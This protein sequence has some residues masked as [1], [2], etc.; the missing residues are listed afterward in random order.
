MLNNEGGKKY[1][2]ALKFKWQANLIPVYGFKSSFVE[3]LWEYVRV[4][5]ESNSTWA[6]RR[7]RENVG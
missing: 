4:L 5:A 1:H 7:N 2:V 3:Q 6:S